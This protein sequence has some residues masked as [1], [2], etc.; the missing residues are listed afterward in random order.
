MTKLLLI[1][2]T[3]WVW[4][5]LS[6]V[7]L[8]AAQLVDACTG[9]P[10]KSNDGKERTRLLFACIEKLAEELEARPT[11]PSGAVVAFDRECPSNGWELYDRAGGRFVVGAGH[12]ANRDANGE[13]LTIYQ[14]H[15]INGGEEKHTLTTE[16]MPS[17]NH[18]VYPHAGFVLANSGQQGAG[19]EDPHATS[20]VANGVTSI[21]GMGKAHNNMP[22]FVTLNYCLKN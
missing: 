16:E 17:H 13:Q 22:P 6:A 15:R 18:A 10:T 5:F 20:N 21:A 1:G 2:I 19:S 8:A 14:K 4:V 11:V 9:I 12:H 3:L 7:P